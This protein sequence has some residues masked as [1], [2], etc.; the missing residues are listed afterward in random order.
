[1]PQSFGGNA[2]FGLMNNAVKSTRSW[3]DPRRRQGQID[4]IER[5]DGHEYA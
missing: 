1:M 4:R 3:S 5:V 2:L